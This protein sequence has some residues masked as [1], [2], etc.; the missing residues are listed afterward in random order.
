MEDIKQIRNSFEQELVDK[1]YKF[2]RD[3]W[4]NSLR[5][6]QRFIYDDKG[7]KYVITGY[8]YNHKEQGL[9]VDD[10]GDKYTFGTYFYIGGAKEQHIE[11][12]FNADFL[13]NK[14]RPES[15][16]EE[17]EEFFEKIFDCS[18]A[19]HKELNPF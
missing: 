1:G 16:L 6:F 12:K 5:G 7:L 10:T 3:N 2:F 13:P 4:K 19:K 15:T 8:H 14:Y 17:V 18:G 11:V 9:H